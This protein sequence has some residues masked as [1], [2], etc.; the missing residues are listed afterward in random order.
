MNIAPPQSA[1]AAPQPG[2]SGIACLTAIARFHGLD[3]SEMQLVQFAAPGAD[4][5]KP[6][7]LVQVARKIDLSAK[8]TRLSWDRLRRLGQA[9][10]A[11]LVLRDGG[12]VVLSGVRDTAEARD[13]VV[14]DPRAPQGFQFWDADKAQAEWDGRVILVKR[15]YALTDTSQPFSLR[16]FIPRSRSRRRSSSS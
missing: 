8:L 5:I 2:L 10:P 14:R 16:W 15:S 7:H 13:I 3:Y 6:A 4:G 1:V 12:A 11:I 9:L